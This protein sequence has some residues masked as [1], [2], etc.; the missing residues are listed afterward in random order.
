LSSSLKRKAA[1]ITD[2]RAQVPKE[3][4]CPN[5]PDLSTANLY[6]QQLPDQNFSAGK[7]SPVF[8]STFWTHKKDPKIASIPD[9]VPLKFDNSMLQFPALPARQAQRT[10]AN[11]T[12]PLACIISVEVAHDVWGLRVKDR[13]V[14]LA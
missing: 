2:L 9:L 1:A 3:P 4:H 6:Q 12:S 8:V 13:D 7:Q 11:H 14:I 10:N 5:H